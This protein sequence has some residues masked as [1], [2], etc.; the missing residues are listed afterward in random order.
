MGGIFLEMEDF[1]EIFLRN[2]EELKNKEIIY[3]VGSSELSRI[4]DIK[5][6]HGDTQ[7]VNFSIV[8]LQTNQFLQLILSVDELKS[9]QFANQFN[10]SGDPHKFFMYMM[11]NVIRLNFNQDPLFAVG[12]SK[13]DPLPH[14]LLAVYKYILPRPNIRFMIAD[15]PGAGKTIMAGIAVKE[16]LTRG[17]VRRILIVVP[18]S[19]TGQ[20]QEELKERFNE[21]FTIIDSNMLQSLGP[22]AWSQFDK[23]LTSMDFAKNEVQKKRKK[24][25]KVIRN[26]L[27]GV[28]W[29]LVIVDEAH[30]MSAE[31]IFKTNQ[32]KITQRYELGIALSESTDH[33]LFLTA[34]P[35]KGKSDSFRLLL[36]LLEFDTFDT[37]HMDINAVLEQL[38]DEGYPIFI[39]RL[40]EKM[41]TADNTPIFPPRNAK[42][43][44]F[45]LSTLE[46]ILYQQVTDYVKKI[47]NL[48]ISAGGQSRTAIGFMLK[49]LQRRLNSSVRAIHLTLIHRK[50]RLEEIL[51][52]PDF[53]K[54]L[55]ELRSRIEKLSREVEEAELNDDIP[56]KKVEELHKE[57][58]CLT[59]ASNREELETEIETLEKLISSAKEA[60]SEECES[61]LYK[62]LEL[63]EENL[64]T[65]QLIIFTEYKDTLDYL[66]EQIPDNFEKGIIHGGMSHSER[67]TVQDKFWNNEIQ[68][69]LCTDAASEGINLQCCWNLINYDIPWN[70][71]RLEQRMGRIHRY[72]QDHECTF[73]NLVATETS[74]GQPIAEGQVVERIFEKLEIMRE[75]LG[76]TDRVFDVIGEIFETYNF[77]DLLIQSLNKEPID[78]TAQ[79]TNFNK[80]KIKKF[81]DFKSNA[82]AGLEFF[83]QQR[84]LS[85]DNRLWPKYISE[86]VRFGFW[87]AGSQIQV[88]D[89]GPFKIQVPPRINAQIKRNERKFGTIS[90]RNL[91]ITFYK[92]VEK[93]LLVNVKQSDYVTAGH[94]L[95]EAIV[96]LSIKNG[97]DSIQKGTI[98]LDPSHG[99]NGLLW[100]IEITFKD[101]TGIKE[102]S[103]QVII[104][105]TPISDT[106]N[107]NFDEISNQILSPHILWDLRRDFS[108]ASRVQLEPYRE[109]FSHYREYIV[110]GL[111]ARL[112]LDEE[113]KLKKWREKAKKIKFNSLEHREVREKSRLEAEISALLDREAEGE[114]VSQK[115]LEK[116]AQ[117]D[118]IS[119]LIKD[120]K[121]KVERECTIMR[122]SPRLLSVSVVV[123]A[124]NDGQPAINIEEA[125]KLADKHEIDMAAMQAVFDFEGAR[126]WNTKDKSHIKCGYDIESVNKSDQLEI[127]HIEVKGHKGEDDV[128]ISKNEWMK[129]QNDIP[130]RYWL[131]V[132][133]NALDNPQV[134]PISDPAN[135]FDP[136]KIITEKYVIPLKQI[137][138]FY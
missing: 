59:M 53:D 3:P 83:L 85:E 56:T 133:N 30:K 76:G 51:N 100:F 20:W 107:E 103:K 114:D 111:G 62:L 58:F 39:R 88:S 124:Y 19:L 74:D 9:I 11:G 81:L 31:W 44:S 84:Q 108:A 15:E 136:E 104:L 22:R 35:H 73:F 65:Q 126:G 118:N 24:G 95:L 8:N 90:N 78:L 128:F 25:K 10:F 41:V 60:E 32:L 115:I 112:C 36:R 42:T 2:P 55:K 4:I 102:V 120:L 86:Y 21:D 122:Q 121:I 123:P 131:Y 82:D 47:F 80:E 40:K 18:G 38:S 67:K 93:Q 119:E 26:S 5:L 125:T 37:A 77:K 96:D 101:G 1:Y 46:S 75:E 132:V 109:F 92:P 105:Y 135:K 16:L 97:Q 49:L 29:D 69:L 14:Q 87:D 138:E 70:P 63:I 116:E 99:L 91:E 17:D 113:I 13:I 52:N 98:F 23:I 61:K 33:F 34:T 64:G 117:R 130:G 43:I 28:Q 137:K 45:T 54:S 94:P 68:I 72:L 134:I 66:L 27:L 71:N 57:I 110:G 127:R 79:D 50:Q 129:A 7:K 106:S 12:S 48:A 89:N 6:V